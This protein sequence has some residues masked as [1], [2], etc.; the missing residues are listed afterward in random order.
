MRPFQPARVGGSHTSNLIS[1]SVEGR[2]TPCTRQNGTATS[3][4]PPGPVT[5]SGGVTIVAL[6]IVAE[7][8]VTEVR[9]SQD[10]AVAGAAAGELPP[11]PPPPQAPSKR[12]PANSAASRARFSEGIS[13]QWGKRSLLDR[14]ALSPWYEGLAA[15]GLTSR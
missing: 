5:L 14:M 10:C 7:S 6:V 1:E 9:L 8:E 12:V 15:P 3:A 13:M 2:A 4:V 11:P